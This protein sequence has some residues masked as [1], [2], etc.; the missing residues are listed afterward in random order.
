MTTPTIAELFDLKGKGAIVTGGGMGIGQ[1]IA[2]RLAEAGAGL[3][4]ADIDLDAA[5]QTVEQIKNNGG[6]AHAIKADA[7]SESDADSVVRATLEAFGSLDILVN[8]AGIF[9]HTLVLEVTEEMWDRVLDINVKGVYFYSRAAAKEMIRAGNGGK[10]VNMASMEG[11][12]PREDLVHYVTS[13]AGVVMLTKA[14]ALELAPHNILVNAVAP[15]GIMTPGA[16][17]QRGAIKATGKSLK[18][19]YETFI[20]HLPL[21]RYGETDEVARV[22]LFLASRASDYMTGSIV[23]ADGGYLLS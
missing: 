7:S 2:L 21:R 4:I 9:P 17:A 8:N 12:H 10:I 3:M 20:A 13:K 5:N 22:V 18:E 6:K 14:L 1:A 11:L 19:V 15:G 16:A 23:V